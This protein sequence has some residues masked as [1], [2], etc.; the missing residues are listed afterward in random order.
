MSK[1]K[2]YQLSDS[3]REFLVTASAGFLSSNDFDKVY[4]KFESSAE[5]YFFNNSSEANLFRILS[6]FFDK[7]SFLLDALKYEHHIEIVSAVSSLSNY[8]T[9]I[10]VRNPEYL[11]TLFN[12]ETLLKQIDEN[13]FKIEIENSISGFKSFSSKIRMLRNFKRK[14]LLKI[15]AA[16]ILG[17]NDIKT[18]T[19]QL[20]VLSRVLAST[21]FEVCYNEIQN[22]Y[23]IKLDEKYCLCSL[24]KLGGNE[25]NY[26]SDIDLILFYEGNNEFSG[27]KKDY[28]ELM[29]ETTQLFIKEATA[30]TPESYLYRVDFR[31]RPDGRNSILCRTMNDYIKYYET[32]GEDWERQMLIKLGFV[33][34]SMELY[35]DF[36]NYLD[37]FIYPRT[38]HNSVISTIQKMKRSIEERLK[39]EKNIKLIPGG[40]R[41]IEFCVQALQLI[42]GGKYSELKSPNTLE[43]LNK[44]LNRGLI[45]SEE[46]DALFNGY[47]LFRKIEHFVQLMND[48]QTHSLPEA[49]ADKEKLA[50]FLNFNS[51]DDLYNH[52]TKYRENVRKIYNEI[53]GSSLKVE[54]DFYSSIEF[55]NPSK[56][57]ANIKFLSLGMG[58][59]GEKQFDHT[60]IKLFEEIEP[61]L[62]EYLKSSFDPDL[63]LENFVRVI[64]NIKLT[65]VW[66]RTFSDKLFLNSFLRLC[67]FNQKAI[68][69]MATSRRLADLFLSKKVFQPINVDEATP[70]LSDTIF[71]LSIQHSAGITTYPDF[72]IVLRKVIE[73]ELKNIFCEQ[74]NKFEF[75]AA[76]LGSFAND[77]INFASDIDLI[78]VVDNIKKYPQVEKDFQDLLTQIRKKLTPFPV[79][80][81]LRPEGKSSQLVWDLDGYDRYINKRMRVWEFR[82]L[83]KLRFI[84]GSKNLYELFVEKI[85][86][87]LSGIDDET[88]AKEISK[89]NRRKNYSSVSDQVKINL[90]TSP[91][92]LS[93]IDTIISIQLLKDAGLF[94]KQLNSGSLNKIEVIEFP[95][96]QFDKNIFR[97][98]YIFI[99]NIQ[100][101]L[102]NL[103]NQSKSVLPGDK[104][105]IEL[106]AL[107]LGYQNSQLFLSKLNSILKENTKLVKN[108]IG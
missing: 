65:S 46:F 54:I 8:L 58:L 99:K 83:A 4:N 15:G 101:G 40:I 19:E 84:E 94:V 47:I 39:D 18:T 85:Q 20:S 44:L 42:N 61:V 56:S 100:I 71:I 16:D 38:F 57:K 43:V 55:R 6:A 98:N 73:K 36:K 75:F 89:M 74:K 66:Y 45:S 35:N 91:G 80:F 48:T 59:L 60:T 33:T 90:K 53:L 26:S 64:K 51:V 96:S 107:Y 102:Q 28:H 70:S 86:T 78:V 1:P 104:I 108:I 63:I 41:D 27:I 13:K 93:D 9:D 106:L 17:F 21:L 95:D 103:F 97:E 68:D 105:K 87:R 29:I 30:V 77:E 82:A 50:F 49:D 76:A 24:G 92:T 72:S 23:S 25:L 69:L 31:L 88:I 32:R 12:Q 7:K 22:K 79:D 81:R 52:V 5:K 14:Y 67:Q 3:F 37:G 34:G 62:I 11:Y 10:I 2:T